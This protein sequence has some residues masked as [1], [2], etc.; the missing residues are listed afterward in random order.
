MLTLSNPGCDFVR[1]WQILVGMLSD[2]QQFFA[3][4]YK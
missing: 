1:H 4:L 3:V 2:D